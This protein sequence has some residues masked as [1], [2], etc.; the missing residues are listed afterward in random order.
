MSNPHQEL[1][2]PD[3]TV[4]G[5]DSSN[6]LM[7]DNLPKIVWY[8]THHVTLIKSWLVQKQT[9]LGKDKSNPLIV[10][11]LLKTVWSSIHHLLINEVLTIQRQTTTGA[12]TPRSDEDRLELIELMVFLLPSDKKGDLTTHTTKYI[13]STQTQKVFANMRRVGKGFFRVKTPLFEGMLVEQ[14]VVEEGDAEVHGE[15]VNGGDAAKGDVSAA[16]GEVPTTDEEPSI[17]SLTP[18]T[19][20]PQPYQD[21][22]STSQRVESSDETMMDDVSNQGRMIAKMDQDVD[23]VLKDDKEVA[24]D[25][26]EVANDDKDDQKEAKIITEVVTTSSETITTSS[27]TINTAEAHVPATTLTAAPARVTAASSK[28][29]KG[30]VIKDPEESTTSIIIP[31]ETKSKDKGKGIMVEEPKPLKKRQQIK[32]EKYA[33][34]LEAELNKNIN[35]DE[36]IDHVTR[37]QKRIIYTCS[38]LEESKKCT[39][40]SKSQGLEAVGILWCTDHYVYHH[41]ADFVSGE[42]VPT[43]KV[44]S[45]LD[46]KCKPSESEGFEQIIDFLNAKPIRFALTVNSTVY[47]SCVKQFWM[48][49]KVKK[50]NGQEDIQALVDK[51]KVIIMEESIRRDL[52][53]DKAEVTACLPN[54]TIFAELARMG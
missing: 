50:V 36:A 41:T 27:T 44:Y 48:T 40:S 33:R 20:P 21:I 7:A 15:E 12:N 37:R 11:S 47:A 10:D 45:G 17:P 9:A 30:V 34:E 19:P 18:P 38:N 5:K 26:K 8:S 1:A 28:K 23:V 3:Q 43:H 49:A 35:W 14:Q 24:D 22:P 29:R 39:W 42:E 31:A 51:Q 2:S 6:P 53:F 52:K 4:S 54:D 16:H 13:S 46:V 32:H 25:D